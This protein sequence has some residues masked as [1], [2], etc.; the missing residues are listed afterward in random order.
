[1]KGK[2]LLIM[3]LVLAFVIGVLL[4]LTLFLPTLRRP[5]PPIP[6]IQV[7]PLYQQPSKQDTFIKPYT[8]EKAQ[9]LYDPFTSKTLQITRLQEEMD[10]RNMEIE[11]LKLELE[12]IKLQAQIDSIKKE[13]GISAPSYRG[14]TISV[15]A[16][17]SS[18]GVMKALLDD[19]VKRT[20]V[21]EGTMYFGYYVVKIENNRVHLRRSTGESL[22]ITP[23]E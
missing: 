16:V 1:M 12:K 8:F 9:N 10:L 17:S 21:K 23:G 4:I 15:L 22:T 13:R 19:G 11:L 18:G 6:Q 20:W 2:N 5:T 7:S 14:T 3:L